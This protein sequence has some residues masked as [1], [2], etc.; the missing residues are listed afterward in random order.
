MKTNLYVILQ[1]YLQF[2][3]KLIKSKEL[4]KNLI[5][6]W[7]DTQAQEAQTHVLL[8]MSAFTHHVCVYVLL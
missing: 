6:I 4:P 3:L 1:I 8:R 7:A 2:E 5:K